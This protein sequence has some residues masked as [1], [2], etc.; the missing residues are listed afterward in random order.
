MNIDIPHQVTRQ[1]RV[2]REN[3]TWICDFY[4][5]AVKGRGLNSRTDIFLK[6]VAMRLGEVEGRCENTLR[7]LRHQETH[8]I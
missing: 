5:V 1:R 8:S 3:L 2:T 4:T 7:A 6:I